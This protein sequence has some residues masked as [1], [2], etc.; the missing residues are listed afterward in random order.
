[1]IFYDFIYCIKN[2]NKCGFENNITSCF[3]DEDPNY[4][5]TE[6]YFSEWYD[7]VKNIAYTPKSYICDYEDLF[8]G[9]I[10]MIINKLPEKQCFA[11]LDTLSTKPLVPYKNSREIVCDFETSARTN[12]YFTKD[13]K[14]IIREYL[15]LNGIEFRC[16]IHNKTLRAI[17]SEGDFNLKEIETLIN[18]IT[19]YTEYDSYCIDFTYYQNKLMVIEINTPVWLFACSGLFDLD[20]PSDCEILFGNY[21]PD[22]INYPV[23]KKNDLNKNQLF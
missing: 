10:D 6:Y 1:M 13:M 17:S 18:K 22:I 23:I 7:I 5:A 15:I 11:R 16:F 20:L 21:M 2:M 4:L 8:N 3:T 19:F 12:A 9:K 14:V